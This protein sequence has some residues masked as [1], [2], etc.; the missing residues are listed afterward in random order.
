LTKAD[1]F[2]RA[3]DKR[4]DAGWLAERLA[5]P[6]ARFVAVWQDRQ[7]FT[8]EDPPQPRWLTA[9]ELGPGLAQAEMV[10]FLGLAG[11]QACFAVG[12]IATEPPCTELGRWLDLRF[13]GGAL[14]P[15]VWE[16]LAYAR[17]L[18]YWHHRNRFCGECGSPTVSAEGGHV[19]LC[20][21]PACGQRHFPRTDPAII[22]LVTDGERCLLGRQAAWPA[23]RYSTL[24]GFVEPGESLEE[25]IAREVQEETSVQVQT[26]HYF[27]SQPWPFPGSLMLG[28]TAQAATTA[29]Q[30]HDGELEDAR[31]FSRAE[32][33]AGLQN[34]TL[35]LSPSFAIS[36]QLIEHWFDADEPGALRRLL[37]S[38]R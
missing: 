14:E 10:A 11:D 32:L 30:R 22:V 21:N 7:L 29:I 34:G 3:T 6:T 17:A 4:L 28:F 37:A 9:E 33:A 12:L 18:S 24:A 8:L 13:S 27:R 15:A 20:T 23:G 1:E 19:R 26:A 38:L 35:R 5:D 16:L 2:N 36:Y 25:A 31:W